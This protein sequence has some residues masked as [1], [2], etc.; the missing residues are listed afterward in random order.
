MIASL[1]LALAFPA[2]IRSA[3]PED[4]DAS[5]PCP[6]AAA[7]RQAHRDELPRALA[8]R[9]G[10]RTFGAPALRA[11]LERRFEADQRERRRLIINSADREAADRV[12]RMDAQNL[13][14][15]KELV[16]GPGIPTVAQVGEMGVH[17]TWLLVQHADDDPAFQASVLPMFAER[18]AAGELP[19]DDL[20]RL[21]DRVLL[22]AGKAQRFG[23]Q[24]D[25]YSGQFKPTGVLDLTA[26]EESRRAFGLMPL[27]DYAC[28]MNAK[29]KRSAGGA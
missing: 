20:A 13:A 23:T 19:A 1:G 24:F 6:G 2:A 7:W 4:S 29:L 9:D 5:A 18:Q 26:V 28:M 11:E 17:W 14:W 15:L 3:A 12:R 21:T 25:W 22:A 10:T 8:E 27:A 16:K